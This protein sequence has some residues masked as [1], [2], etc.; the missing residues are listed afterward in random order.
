MKLSRKIRSSAS[1]PV[2][3]AFTLIELLVVIAIIAILAA[4]LLPALSMA[5]L[6]ATESACINNQKQLLLASMMYAG[7]NNDAIIPSSFNGKP[8]NGGGWWGGPTPPLY[9]GLSAASALSRDQNGLSNSPLY[10]YNIRIGTMH[11]PGDTRIRNPVG[12]GWAYDSYS[13]VDPMSG[14]GWNGQVDFTKMSNIRQPSMSF[15][16]IEE[17]DSRGYNLST[18]VFNTTPPGWAD[19]FAIFHGDVTTFGY[20]DGHAA[21]HKW[22]ESSTVQA[23]EASAQGKLMLFWKG[24]NAS[25]PDFVWVWNGYRFQNWQPL[26]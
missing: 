17:A 18:W 5:K 8:M 7:D 14:G 15:F 12:S 19:V 9:S 3:R 24:G 11:C 26:P 2:R 16:F 25:N 21:A 6:K 22:L 20:A 1:L 13:K 4:L 10:T 23:G